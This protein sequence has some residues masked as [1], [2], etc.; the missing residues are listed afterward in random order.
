M[1]RDDIERIARRAL[2][3]LGADLS[4]LS[5]L[6][7]DGRPDQWRVEIGGATKPLIINCGRG[8]TAQW[9]RQQICD[10]YLGQS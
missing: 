4:Q 5:V 10:K 1:D 8:S 9:V 3:D 6:A 7:V 2:K